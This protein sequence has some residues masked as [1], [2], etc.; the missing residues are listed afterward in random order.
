MGRK[1]TQWPALKDMRHLSS[2]SVQR[3]AKLP[4]ERA[5]ASLEPLDCR[6]ETSVY[7]FVKQARRHAQR[8]LPEATAKTPAVKA[9]RHPRINK[10]VHY[11]QRREGQWNTKRN[12][13][14]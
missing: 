9:T 12:D 13:D 4:S 7:L 6:R 5:H 3:V 2:N 11:K 1:R 10:N 14:P 8:L